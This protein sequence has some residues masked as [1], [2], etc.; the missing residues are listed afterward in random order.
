[1]CNWRRE[2]RKVPFEAALKVSAFQKS[3]P[4]NPVAPKDNL[5]SGCSRREDS[6]PEPRL[7]SLDPLS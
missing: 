7:S 4:L 5:K 3:S 2:T 1:M 6:P